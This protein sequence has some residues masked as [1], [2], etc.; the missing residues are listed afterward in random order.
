MRAQAQ[1][2]R[3]QQLL[4]LGHAVKEVAFE[5]GFGSPESFERAY[6]RA[7]GRRPSEFGKKVVGDGLP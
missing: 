2:A 6:R 3:A 5:L 4:G 7:C 1:V